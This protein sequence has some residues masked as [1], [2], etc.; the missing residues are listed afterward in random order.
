MSHLKSF[1]FVEVKGEIHENPFQ[2]F[3]TVHAVNFHPPEQKRKPETI[4][5]SL[6]DAK[7]LVENGNSE[8]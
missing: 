8:G 2:A 7:A 4:M 6:R 5:S 3:E 1:R